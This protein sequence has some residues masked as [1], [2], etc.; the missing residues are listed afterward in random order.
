MTIFIRRLVH[1]RHNNPVPGIIIQPAFVPKWIRAFWLDIV[2]RICASTTEFQWRVA[3][4]RRRRKRHGDLPKGPRPSAP[5]VLFRA[6]TELCGVPGPSS[7][8][9]HVDS[10][11]AATSAAICPALDAH[12]II[13]VFDDEVGS[14]RRCSTS[15]LRLGGMRWCREHDCGLN[16]HLLHR[17][18]GRTGTK[19][20][21]SFV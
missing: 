8:R 19:L 13:A 16:R 9:A 7:V 11:N 2:A 20:R 21:V 15:R 5:R 1:Y 17:K 6:L 12:R 3:R 4:P 10:G 14:H 18:D